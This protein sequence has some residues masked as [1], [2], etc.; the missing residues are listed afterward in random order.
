MASTSEGGYAGRVIVAAAVLLVTRGEHMTGSEILVVD[1]DADIRSAL[2]QALEFEGYRV[3][4]AANGREAWDSL[5]SAPAPALILLDLMMPVMNG[6]EFLDL[7]RRDEQ[8]RAVPVVVVT[9]F[10][11]AVAPIAAEAQGVLSKPLDLEQ[12]IGVA[13]RFCPPRR[14]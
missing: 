2:T 14:S 6:A 13:S 9:A 10:G 3:A 8:L 7:L 11:S 5:R 1:D 12:L 4:S